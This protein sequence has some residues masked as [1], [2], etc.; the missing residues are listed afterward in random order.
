[1]KA[2]IESAEHHFLT[3]LEQLKDKSSG[4]SVFYF[5]LSKFLNHKDMVGNPSVIEKNIAAEREKSLAIMNDLIARSTNVRDGYVYIFSDNDVLMLVHARNEQEQEIAQKIYW[6]IAKPLPAGF[7]EMGTL[8]GGFYS[9]QK[10]ADRK[11]L[12][13]R[14]FEAYHAMTNQNKV[15]S[16]FLRRERREESKIMIVEDDRFTAAY[17]ANILNHDYDL[18]VCRSGEEAIIAYIEQAPDVV[19]LDIHLPGL[20]GHETLQAIRA[21]D[22]KAFVVMLSVDSAKDSIVQATANGASCF[23]KKPFSRQRLLSIVKTSPYV[24]GAYV[25]PAVPSVPNIMIGEPAK[26]EDVLVQ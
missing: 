4:W 16:I 8:S 2:I 26:T 19:F 13:A 6:E 15:S 12:S 11:F 17:T 18:Q 3:T 20:N 21:V 1:M 7:A 22:P 10:L 23:L 14:R 9:Y 25:D 24:R 5:G